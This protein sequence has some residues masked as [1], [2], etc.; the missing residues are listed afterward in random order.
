MP[1]SSL[2]K[3][4]EGSWITHGFLARDDDYVEVHEGRKQ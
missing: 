4:R 1:V 2:I 3:E